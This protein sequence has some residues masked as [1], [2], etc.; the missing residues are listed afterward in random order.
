MSRASEKLRPL[1]ACRAGAPAEDRLHEPEHTRAPRAATHHV[2]APVPR[3]HCDQSHGRPGAQRDRSFVV[4]D[5]HSVW[6]L[7]HHDQNR[8]IVALHSPADAAP[9]RDRFEE[10]WEL[11]EP[12]ISSSTLGL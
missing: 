12:A 7:Q 5:D 1:P 4:A 9:I 3:L 2:V 11:S 10:I 8:A 6:H